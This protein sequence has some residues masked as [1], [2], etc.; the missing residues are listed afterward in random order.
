MFLKSEFGWVTTC[1]K[2][3]YA[4]DKSRFSSRSGVRRF[5]DVVAEFGRRNENVGVLVGS[6]QTP[7]LG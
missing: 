1:E 7:I 2:F 4:H 6:W 3:A 5:D